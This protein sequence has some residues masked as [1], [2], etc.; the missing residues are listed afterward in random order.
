MRGVWVCTTMPGSTGVVQDAGVPFFP[1]ISTR[2]S[3]QEPNGCSES[4]AHSL[5]TAKPASDASLITD[6]PA[7]TVTITP[8]MSTDTVCSDADAGVPWSGSF[9]SVIA[10]ARRSLIGGSPRRSA[11]PRCAPA[12]A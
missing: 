7:G 1:S 2:H 6:V 4:V 5:G 11:P 9:R 3:R 8:S 10:V 12:A